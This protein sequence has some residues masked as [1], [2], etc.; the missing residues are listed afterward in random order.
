MK[1]NITILYVED[2][3]QIRENTKR[4]LDRLCSKLFVASNGKEGLEFYKRY[5]PDIVIS[6]IKMP[7]MNGIEMC[8]EIKNI[9]TKQHIIFT[10]AH[11]DSLYFMEAIDMQVDGYILKPIEYDLLK[12]KIDNIIEQINIANSLKEQEILCSEVTRFQ[13]N[14]LFVLD[15]IRE[16]IFA[17]DKFLEFFN[18]QSFEEFNNIYKDIGNL[19][20]K[21]SGCFYPKEDRYWLDDLKQT[22]DEKRRVIT[23]KDSKDSLRVFVITFNEVKETAHSVFILTEITN[24]NREKNSLKEN[25][26]IDA[27]T[28]VPN[29]FYIDRQFTIEIAKKRRENTNFS[30]II[31]DIDSFKNFNDTYGHLVGDQILLGLSE[32]IVKNKREIDIF[33]RWGGE[34]FMILLPNTSLDGAKIVA[35]KFR[36]LIEQYKFYNNLQLTCSFGISEFKEYDT[37]ESFIKRADDA[38][39]M[40]KKN[41][42]NRVEF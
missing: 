22:K 37:K 8:K 20:I 41:G 18:I 24:L 25:V 17:N 42:R 11:S 21:N 1:K 12:N 27:L 26:Y 16:V 3:D 23:L 13:N 31:L 19:F 4:P 40:A 15:E 38:L 5:N 35:N 36:K 32:F 7:S 2:E 39:Y 33:G 34:E 9:N 28:Q 6:D 10:T 14:L 30:L 29:R